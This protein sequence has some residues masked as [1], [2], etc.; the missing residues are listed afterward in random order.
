MA[1][2]MP[3]HHWHKRPQKNAQIF[4]PEDRGTIVVFPTVGV[5]PKRSTNSQKSRPRD[6][7]NLSGTLLQS[8]LPLC[9]HFVPRRQRTISL[10]GLGQWGKID[11]FNPPPGD[12]DEILF[13][14][15]HSFRRRF[16]SQ[17]LKFFWKFHP[18][19]NAIFNKKCEN[20]GR[21]VQRRQ[22]VQRK[23]TGP[24]GTNPWYSV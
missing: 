21:I 6:D 24:I 14:K 3:C 23:K 10:A 5:Q 11:I 15:K 12:D 7:G 17:S 1:A 19:K 9:H 18:K 2:F 20:Y 8:H 22:Q 16:V 4:C 13:E